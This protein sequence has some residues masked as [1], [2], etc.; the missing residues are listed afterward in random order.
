MVKVDPV[1]QIHNF[2]QLKQIDAY[3]KWH[4][5]ISEKLAVELDEKERELFCRSMNAETPLEAS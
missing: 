2:K 4:K 5:N 1:K 3:R